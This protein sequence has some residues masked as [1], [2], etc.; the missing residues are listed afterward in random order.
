MPLLMAKYS[1]TWIYEVH[2]FSDLYL[3]LQ[4][5]SIDQWVCFCANTNAYLLYNLCNLQS[6]VQ[7][8]IRDGDTSPSSFTI[9]DCLAILLF[10]VFPFEAE[11]CPFKFC[12]ELC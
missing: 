6:V 7:F 2:S 3:V 12:E 11:N 5:N 8:E 4:F 10:S 9:Q 1:N